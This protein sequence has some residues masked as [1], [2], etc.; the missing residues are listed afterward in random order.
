MRK[1]SF[2]FIPVTLLA[3]VFAFFIRKGDLAI[4]Y[5]STGFQPK[6]TGAAL[7][8]ISIVVIVAF[9]AISILILG[10]RS[11]GGKQ[12]PHT[13]AFD[14]GVIA[15]W[16]QFIASAL[17]IVGAVLYVRGVS[18][19]G[20]HTPYTELAVF[21]MWAL[22]GIAFIMLA[23]NG[24]SGRG[25][26][27]TVLS[28][29]PPLFFSLMLIM[30]YR[31]NSSNPV[32][33]S[34]C[35]QILAQAVAALSTYYEAGYIYGREKPWGQACTLALT[36]FFSCAALA[37]AMAMSAAHSLLYG[38]LVLLSFTKLCVLLLNY[39]ADSDKHKGSASSEV[40]A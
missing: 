13:I 32:I 17:F 24:Y 8:V 19:M 3:S 18:V 11:R 37:D 4:A 10:T 22:S 20:G 23:F 29:I 31:D 35:Y 21:A 2:F 33:S 12:L 9:I 14:G 5:E 36:T 27:L 6:G 39:S 28:V 25:T 40:E 34:Y 38:S 30:T 15:M 1:A 7:S 26:G 16:V